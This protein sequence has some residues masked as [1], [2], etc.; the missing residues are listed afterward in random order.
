MVEYLKHVL[1]KF[2]ACEQSE[3]QQ[4]VKAIAMILHFNNDEEKL[5]REVLDYRTSWFSSKPS[6]RKLMS[7]ASAKNK[8]STRSRR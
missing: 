2:I 1:L 4:L 8:N 5:V 3:A 6:S 7:K